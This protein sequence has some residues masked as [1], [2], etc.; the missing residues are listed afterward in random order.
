MLG[1]LEAGGRPSPAAVRWPEAIA[2]I[3]AGWMIARSMSPQVWPSAGSPFRCLLV[4]QPRGDRSIRQYG[5]RLDH[6]TGRVAA[7]D[8][9][10]TEGS[11]WV[12]GLWAAV[13]FLAGGWP[14]LVVIALAVIVVGRVELK[15]FSSVWY[16]RPLLTLIAWS[17]WTMRASSVELWAAALSLPFTRKP[18]WSLGVSVLVAWASPGARFRCWL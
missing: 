8:R 11:D 6:G 3:V 14:P 17:A 9:L 12:T 15:V 1:R 7:I 10:I 18:D 16:C 13:A 2:A 4:R 5:H